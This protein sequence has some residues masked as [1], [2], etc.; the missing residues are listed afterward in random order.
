[1]RP[2]NR[3]PRRAAAK[4]AG[5]RNLPEEQTMNDEIEAL[6]AALSDKEKSRLLRAAAVRSANRVARS[7]Q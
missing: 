1:V 5:L 2:A 3:H 4:I 7:D 6:W